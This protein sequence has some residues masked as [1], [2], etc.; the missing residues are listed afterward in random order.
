MPFHDRH[1]AWFMSLPIVVAALAALTLVADGCGG[2]TGGNTG[3]QVANWP[4]MEL[5]SPDFPDGGELPRAMACTELGGENRSPALAWQGAPAGTVSYAVIMDDEDPPCGSGEGA[6]RHWALYNLP[7]SVSSLQ[8]GEEASLTGAALGANYQG[9][10]G[11]AGP[12][13]P[14]RHR[15]RITVYTLGEGMPRLDPGLELTRAGF[16]RQYGS[17]I[18]ARGTISGYLGP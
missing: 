1:R 3:G 2:G 10:T 14:S 17:Y 13:P 9:E 5:S 6:C 18:L 7:A 15:Y 8:A 16:E 11:Y 4:A 12:C